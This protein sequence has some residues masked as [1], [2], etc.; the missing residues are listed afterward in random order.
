MQGR[1]APDG[2]HHLHARTFAVSALHVHDLVSLPHAQVDWLLD[3]LV[4]VAHG[5]QGGVAH[6][7]AGFDQ[8]A[9]LQQPHAQPVAAGF[10]A[11]HEAAN[12]QVVQD[13]VG[14]G[15]VQPRLFADFLQGDCVFTGGQHVDQRK[16]ALQHLN[17]GFDGNAGIDFFHGRQ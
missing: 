10:R 12:G 5:G 1:P 2:A 14:G 6:A 17:A 7:Q 9:Q 8:V 3:E 13:A 15:R 16:H 4:Q 11:V